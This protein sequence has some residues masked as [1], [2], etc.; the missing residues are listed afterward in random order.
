MAM[1]YTFGPFRLDETGEI[2]FRGTEPLPVGRRAVG[3]LR[4]LVEQ[5][6]APVSKE[7]FVGSVWSGLA[8]EDSN[9]TAQIAAL[10]K[11]FGEEPGGEHWIETLPRRGYR[12]VGPT[13]TRTEK[14]VG[15][16]WDM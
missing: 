7:A 10:R 9:I 6:G 15:G 4:L 12:F 1:I 11:V 5:P 3:V 14:K 16:E 13:V 2:L 8:V